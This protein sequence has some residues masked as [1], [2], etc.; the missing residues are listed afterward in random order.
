MSNIAN[1]MSIISVHPIRTTC[2]LK[3]L[4][5]IF[6]VDSAKPD[7]SF[8]S[9]T[10]YK[11]ISRIFFLPAML[12]LS[13]TAQNID[14]DEDLPPVC[15]PACAGVI[16]VGRRCNGWFDND[17]HA[18]ACMCDTYGMPIEVP[19]CEVCVADYLDTRNDNID[20]NGYEGRLTA[21]HNSDRC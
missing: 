7:C 17:R 8:I 2:S 6:I 9:N 19:T 5:R 20:E 21:L 14:S 15:R 3:L 1:Y 18:L 12:S 11:M 10:L 13:I 16:D 4:A